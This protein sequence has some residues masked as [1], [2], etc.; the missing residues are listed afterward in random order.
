MSSC[1]PDTL[2]SHIRRRIYTIQNGYNF[3]L[4]KK[5]F[6]LNDEVCNCKYFVHLSLVDNFCKNNPLVEIVV[7]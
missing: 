7:K 5:L 4:P 2:H 6:N 3:A 1:E